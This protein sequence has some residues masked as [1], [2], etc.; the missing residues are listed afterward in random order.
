MSTTEHDDHT[1][2][3]IT[4]SQ[5]KSTNKSGSSSKRPQA[6]ASAKSTQ[7]SQSKTVAFQAEVKQILDLVIHSLYSQKEI[8]L[9]ELI[10]NAY[11]AIE[12]RRLAGLK[13]SE[14]TYDGTPEIWITTDK[15]ARTIT[16]S[17]T[18][19]GMSPKEVET[20]IGT[21]A[22]SGTKEF[23]KK[24]GKIKKNPDLIGQFGVGFYSSFMVAHKVELHTQKA[25][26]KTGTHWE[27][28]GDGSYVLSSLKR[29]DGSGT[30]VTLHLKDLPVED[31]E[32]FTDPWI[33]KSLVKK[34]S[35]F[36]DVPIKTMMEKTETKKDDE[37]KVIE[38]SS[39][40]TYEEQTLNSMKALWRKPSSAVKPEE[41]KEFYKNVCKDWS[42]PLEIIHYKAEGTKEFVALLFIPSQ[43]PFDFY[44]RD[45]DWGPS[46][47]IHKVFISDHVT[48]LLP[49]YLRFV[50]GVV[51][52]D[53]IPLN[54]SREILQK[55]HHIKSL[56]SALQF[57]ILKHFENLLKKDRNQYEK[58]WDLWGSTI[59]EGIA[60][61]FTQKEKLEKLCLFRT[62]IDNRWTTLEEYVSRMKDDQKA[63]YYLTGE[64]KDQ[65]IDSPHMEK[66]KQKSYE[67]LLLVDQVD[68]WVSQ[69]IKEFAGK[70]VVSLSRNDL[71]FD[72]DST[73]EQK[74][75]SQKQQDEFDQQFK[76]LKESML[77][78]LEDHVK[79]V[80]I[81]N[82][83]V[84]SPVCLVTDQYD[85]SARMERIMG[86]LGQSMPKVKR[87]LEINPTHPIIQKMSSLTETKQNSWSYILY[88]QSLL[89]EGSPIENPTTFTKKINELMTELAQKT[90]I[91][92]KKST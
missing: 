22:H 10:S 90:P 63:I 60:T 2:T 36:L 83:L 50:K 56:S 15:K 55:D 27:S 23:S 33:I 49:T 92:S 80:R 61:D 40:T 65:I 13:N 35:D 6:R 43:V 54:V 3:K 41:Y 26:S 11:D 14:L 34:Y 12:K 64:S 24:L 53:D 86:S 32:D 5:K 44:Q 39:Q 68:E 25:G 88:Q 85:P 76:S 57:K 66:I 77:K 7:T 74:Q 75:Q 42:D 52:S 72:E 30:T 31:A 87:I 91:S 1:K 20:N 48:D 69:N 70:D 16:I 37:G 59:K 84:D 67:V 62:T 18:G 38:G 8:F 89:N 58:L 19:I 46:L 73:E 82:R 4:S 78:T 47:Y 51:D 29:K 17:D 45:S 81:S 9:R 71:S 28:T 79:E 21:I